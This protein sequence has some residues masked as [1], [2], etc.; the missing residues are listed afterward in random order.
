MEHPGYY[1]CWIG[2]SIL[3]ALELNNDN[4]L[5]REQY[6]EKKQRLP[7]WSRLNQS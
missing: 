1:L 2:A 7:D 5:V 3:E 4:V 6:L